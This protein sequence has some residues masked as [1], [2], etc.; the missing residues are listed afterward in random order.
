MRS[1]KLSVLFVFFV[2]GS[3]SA[4]EGMWIPL[5]LEKYN[6][7]EMQEMGFK[8]SAQDIYDI[9]HASMKDAV[10]VFGGGCTGEMISPE[11]LLITNHHCG[12][13]QI[14]SHSSVEN[15]YLTDG[16]WAMSRDEELPNPGLSVR[17]LEYMEDVTDEVLEGTEVLETG[18]REKRMKE[19]IAAVQKE[20]SVDG[21]Y[22]TQVKPLFYGNQYYLYVYKVFRD[23]RLVGAPPSAIGKFG[24]DTDNWMWPRHTGDFSLFRVYADKNNEPADYSPD[25][26]PFQPKKF[27]PISLD[28]IQYNDFTMVFGNPGSTQEYI[29]SYEVNIIQNQRDPDRIAI[30]EK[31]L[32][33]FNKAMK[34][35]QKIRI[36]YSAK[37]ASVSNAWKKWQGE[38]KGLERLDAVN[39]KLAF[40]K[41]FKE[42]AVA[43]NTWENE[44]KKVFENFDALYFLYGNYIKAA[45][46]YSEIMVRGIEIFRIA[47]RVNS[48]AGS[49][50]SGEIK[51][52]EN[53]TKSVTEYLPGFFKDFHQPVDEQLFET[54]LPLLSTD[55][56]PEF[57]PGYL[58]EVLAKNRG[59][60][61]LQKI[62]RKSVLTDEQQLTEILKAGD[63]KK[64]LAL[65]KDPLVELYSNL[66]SHF[67]TKIAPVVE[68]LNGRINQNMKIYMAGIMEMKKG[69][70]LYPDANLTLRVTYGKVEGYEPRNGVKYKYYTTLD[71]IIEKDNPDI[72]D[73]NVPER[74]KELYRAKDY[75]RYAANGYL[76]VCFTASNHTTGGNS[77]SPVVNAEGQ[78]IGVNFD[79]CWEGTMS[80]IMYDPEQSRNIA[81]D[82]RYALFLIDKFAGA[83]Y[84][85]EEMELVGGKAN[86]AAE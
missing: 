40:E 57:V 16:F 63:K 66:S 24:G 79:R 75:G 64:L 36:Q 35:D 27:F 21:K 34:S 28:G 83:G 32:A 1:L 17:F 51:S 29:P 69:Q 59:E 54:L 7:A 48:L 13:G 15:D 44:Y 73:Y 23:V 10:V 72:Y 8:L 47:S 68:E 53:Q 20:A 39:K 6:L 76:P 9:N 62:Y 22:M 60:K 18:A 70:P 58:N 3:L 26:V 46:Y 31:K 14:Q 5:L 41:E 37:H 71:G 19:N 2:L 80:D 49:I 52:L 67:E 43:N 45:D 42:W 38:I 86:V 50:E 85:L 30:R 82:I 81:I 78:L 56:S 4:K 65:K 84:L 11:G 61:M 25:N 55:L 74:L 12:Y 33:I 77:G